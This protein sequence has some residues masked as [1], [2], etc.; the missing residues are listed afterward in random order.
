[1]KRNIVAV[2]FF[3]LLV[4]PDV[5]HASELNVFYYNPLGG[6]YYHS[7]KKC[8]SIDEKY[9]SVLERIEQDRLE[10]E[11]SGLKKCERCCKQNDGIEYITEDWILE[12]LQN[13][14]QDHI[15][16]NIPRKD[17]YIVGVDIP[18]GIYTIMAERE[19]AAFFV[20]VG[21]GEERFFEASE[22]ATYTF[23]F[24][25]GSI[26]KLN[27][28][29]R[30]YPYRQVWLFQE[31]QEYIMKNGRYSICLQIP[32]MTYSVK[33]VPG[34]TARIVFS[35]LTSDMNTEFIESIEIEENT[36]IDIRLTYRDGRFIEFYNC[37][38]TPE[39]TEG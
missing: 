5:V 23:Y 11:Y 10:R 26:V 31:N 4:R 27:E 3:L 28:Y 17:E 21:K 33:A 34:T 20:T 2:M 25:E 38:V 19:G 9:W 12:S 37:I 24:S 1:M 14:S 8:D 16:I 22:L 39:E 7:N 15:S 36:S 32:T 18:T 13:M 29:C 6:R 35:S 30:I